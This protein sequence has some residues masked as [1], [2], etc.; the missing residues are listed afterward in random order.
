MI[1]ARRINIH[2]SGASGLGAMDLHHELERIGYAGHVYC[3]VHG[4]LTSAA[5]LG[6]DGVAVGISCTG[7]THDVVESL[8]QA[9]AAR[10]TTVAITNH[11]RSQLAVLAEPTLPGEEAP[12]MNG[13]ATTPAIGGAGGTAAWPRACVAAVD[14]GGTGARVRLSGAAGV[15]QAPGRNRV[16]G[17]HRHRGPAPGLG[18]ALDALRVTRPPLRVE[19]GAVGMS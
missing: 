15:A 7:E 5:L 14:I 3:D 19:A 6:L 11:P 8:R 16:R 17:G 4:G 9:A 1:G 18:R 2:G 10:A 13:P 12:R